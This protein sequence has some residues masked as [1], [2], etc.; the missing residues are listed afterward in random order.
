MKYLPTH[1]IRWRRD[2]DENGNLAT[3]VLSG[4]EIARKVIIPLHVHH[5]FLFIS[6][7]SLPDYD[8]K[9][10]IFTC[11]VMED[12]DTRKRCCFSFSEVVYNSTPDTNVIKSPTRTFYNK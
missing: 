6:L 5:A 10:P 11:P 7:L 12:V 4:Y 9:L 2:S 8:V 3:R 1:F